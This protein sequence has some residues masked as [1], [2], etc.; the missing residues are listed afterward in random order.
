MKKLF[1][2]IQKND[3]ETAKTLLDK[4]P[5][6]ISCTLKGTP[7]AKNAVLGSIY[8]TNQAMV[9]LADDHKTTENIK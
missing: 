3:T 4:S 9:C 7:N 5:E 2:A 1:T 6:L 8:D